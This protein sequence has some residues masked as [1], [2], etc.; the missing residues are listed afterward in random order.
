M[1]LIGARQ[2]CFK[3]SHNPGDNRKAMSASA[4]AARM[5]IVSCVGSELTSIDKS[6]GAG[7]PSLRPFQP[8]SLQIRPPPLLAG[9]FTRPGKGVFPPLE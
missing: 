2:H 5:I 4:C 9:E 1:L 3:L 8:L 7:N 6:Y